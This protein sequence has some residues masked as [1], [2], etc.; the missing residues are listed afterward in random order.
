MW[1]TLPDHFNSISLFLPILG[2]GAS[3]WPLRTTQTPITLHQ[4]DQLLWCVWFDFC[5]A[6]AEFLCLLSSSTFTVVRPNFSEN[7]EFQTASAAGQFT[8]ILPAAAKILT[9]CKKLSQSCWYCTESNQFVSWARFPFKWLNNNIPYSLGIKAAS[10]SLHTVVFPRQNVRLHRHLTHN[11]GDAAEGKPSFQAVSWVKTRHQE[12]QEES[13][14]VLYST[15]S[16]C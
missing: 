15:D 6:V 4:V 9:A 12:D 11:A 10:P 2:W 14:G 5:S 16:F 8:W 13:Q 1:L 3:S 7:G